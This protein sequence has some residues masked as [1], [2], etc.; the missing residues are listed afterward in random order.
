MPTP[1]LN[2]ITA[3]SMGNVEAV[4]RL[5]LLEPAGN[6]QRQTMVWAALRGRTECLQLIVPICKQNA[7]DDAFSVALQ[8]DQFSSADALFPHIFDTKLLLIGLASSVHHDHRDFFNRV[9]SRLQMVEH[10]SELEANL[11]ERLRLHEGFTE[12]FWA[13]YNAEE[14]ARQ[15]NV[16]EHSAVSSHNHGQNPRKI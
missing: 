5:L 2:L 1:E 8:H 16:L 15:K 13:W 7:I 11:G 10:W 9:L 6:C 4:K 3:A 12:R 14:A